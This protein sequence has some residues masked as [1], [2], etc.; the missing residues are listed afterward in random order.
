[1]ETA[2]Q[3]QREFYSTS[4]GLVLHAKP[5]KPII[6]NGILSSEREGEKI[7]QFQEFGDFGRYVT[8]DPE[9]IAYLEA[10][11]AKGRTDIIL[12][13]DYNERITPDHVK[14]ATLK[15]AHDVQSRLI[16]EQNK[17]IQELQA[18]LNRTSK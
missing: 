2:V 12:P 13:A 7:I 18:R 14:V 16:T 8:S 17:L 15:N 1:M 4:R 10:Q 3:E 6:Q 5:G 9:E 11:I